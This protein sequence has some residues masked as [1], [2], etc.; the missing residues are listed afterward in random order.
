MKLKVHHIRALEGRRQ[1]VEL[2]VTGPEQAGADSICGATLLACISTGSI[3][4]AMLVGLPR[5][6]GVWLLMVMALPPG[7]GRPR[8]APAAAAE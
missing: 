7:A 5:M 3:L 2:T 4:P 6:Y 1:L 8:A